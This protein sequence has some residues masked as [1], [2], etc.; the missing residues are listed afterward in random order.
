[1]QYPTSSKIEIG[2]PRI[3]VIG[4]GGAGGNAVAAMARDGIGGVRLMAANCDVQALNRC[5]VDE[6][7]R[8]GAGHTGGFGA[9][10]K[11]EIGAAAAEEAL[12]Q[13]ER[14][15]AGM[16]LCFIAAGLG[17]GAGTGASPV[18]ARAA[19][20]MGILT[21]GVVTLPFA[22]EG[23]RRARLAEAGIAELERSVDALIVVPNQNLFRIVGNDTSLRSALALADDVLS[24]AVRSMSQPL[25]TTG[26]KTLSFADVRAAMAGM[27][28]AMIGFG[29]G[30]FAPGRGLRAAEQ[31]VTSPLLD[32][33]VAGAAKLIVSI[34]GGHDMGLLEVDEAVSRVAACAAPDAEILWSATYDATL[35]GVVRV[36]VIATGVPIART[37]EIAPVAVIV[38]PAP[39][40]EILFVPEPVREA[41]SVMVE[42]PIRRAPRMPQ[43]APL[44]IALPVEE[45]IVVEAAAPGPIATAPL[46][47]TS[48]DTPDGELSL[49]SEELLFAPMPFADPDRR[50]ELAEEAEADAH[51]SLLDRVGSAAIGALRGWRPRRA[52]PVR[53]RAIAV[54]QVISRGGAQPEFRRAG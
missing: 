17:G 30:E 29:E 8:L 7:I 13:I 33:G 1:M 4:V 27:G 14:A 36:A 42:H 41:V 31:A 38:A 47:F 32:A 12:P 46:A 5:P 35:E 10:A 49:T 48:V 24:Q 51:Y 52:V 2:N 9:G 15:L 39:I 53:N 16:D 19:R 18:I 50:F 43:P 3:C 25:V 28:R 37:A 20:R 54:V 40:A 22:F 45:V 44:A 23:G 26:M 6:R 21:I 11:A 34:S